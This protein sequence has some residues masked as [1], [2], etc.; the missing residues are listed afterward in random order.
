MPR[1]ERVFCA[2]SWEL[3]KERRAFH[4]ILADVN[5]KHAMPAGFLYVPVSLA[6][7]RDKRPIQYTID[8]NIEDATHYILAL[9]A[10]WGPLERNFERDYYFAL[11]C[12]AD[13]ARPMRNVEFLL[14]ARPDGTPPAFTAELFARGIAHRLFPNTASFEEHVRALLVDWVPANA[15]AAHA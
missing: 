7:I 13:A 11:E 10:D 1:F 9:D 8:Q 4:T 2:T 5:E 12:R 14:R 3:E 15:G 6:N